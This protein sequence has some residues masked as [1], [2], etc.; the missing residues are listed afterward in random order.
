MNKLKFI[1]NFFKKI[2]KFINSLLEKNL[3]K[4]NISNFKKLI[5]N[6]KI[7]LTIVA[8]IIL[9]L[10][11]LSFP[12]I[13][14][15]DE[16]SAE[17][18]KNLIKKLNLEFNFSDNL[19]YHFLPRPH[20]VA[21]RSE[22]ILNDNTISETKKIKIYLSLENLFSLKKM[23][24]KN[25][26][27]EEANFNFNKNNY[28][29]FV[30]LLDS[31]FNDIKLEIVNS[32]IFY[33]NLENDVLFINKILYAKYIYDLN[34]SK[35]ILY[36]NNE[37]FNLPYSIKLFKNKEDKKIYAK[38]DID[39]LRLQTE[40]Q[41]S[42]DGDF[43]SGLS[44]FNILNTRSIAEYKTDKN[45]FEFN[46]FDKAQK[47]KFSYNGKFNFK[48]FH[49]HVTGSSIE[50]NFSHLF[51]SN[52]FIQQLLETEI[53][54][55]KNVDF[56]LSIYGDKIKNFDDF[57]NIILKL[58]I[59][60]GLIDLDLTT[61]SWKNYVNF[62]LVDSL[63]YVKDGKLILDATSEI[64]ITN[65]NEVYKFLV[66]PKKFRKKINKI[67]INFTYLFDEKT[68]NIKD[69]RVDGKIDNKLNN[70]LNDIFIGDNLKNKIYFKRLMNNALKN[71][72]G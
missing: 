66:T 30:R 14:N 23:R 72:A 68:I 39:S 20:F 13:Y 15:Q 52:A 11:Y 59:Q 45:L 38:I 22:I 63:I 27:I 48:P 62:N 4:L 69:V 8:A 70:Y 44:E 58:K 21:T 54:N 10:S 19:E 56:K 67:N 24:V 46:L 28:N 3:N 9:F 47:Q 61:F 41:F 36:F 55:N 32:N 51:S 65:L 43:I 37:I 6:N 12:N 42:F 29:F 33:R 31:N 16:I 25:I 1:A 26:V 2:S 49:S 7:F 34:E 64:N 17:L 53:L 57:T 35:N 18:K 40:N 71:Y 5:I 60:E 50:I